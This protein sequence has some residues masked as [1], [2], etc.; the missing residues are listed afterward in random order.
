MKLSKE[1]IEQ[2]RVAYK[3][4]TGKEL[5]EKIAPKLAEYF[6]RMYCKIFY[7]D[8]ILEFLEEQESN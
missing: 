3:K 8:A 2:F 5:D 1:S 4:E 7:G 6:L